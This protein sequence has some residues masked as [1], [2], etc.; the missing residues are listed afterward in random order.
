MPTVK[1]PT[2]RKRKATDKATSNAKYMRGLSVGETT[3]R[4]PATDSDGTSKYRKKKST[5]DKLMFN[6]DETGYDVI[7]WVSSKTCDSYF[8]IYFYSVTFWYRKFKLISK[9]ARNSYACVPMLCTRICCAIFSIT[10]EMKRK[11]SS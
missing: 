3:T 10:V 2:G 11:F 6:S 7:A 4:L 9:W 5:A 8:L 1:A